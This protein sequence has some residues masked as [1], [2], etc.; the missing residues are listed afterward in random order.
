[1]TKRPLALEKEEGIKRSWAGPK[2]LQMLTMVTGG[3]RKMKKKSPEELRSMK[4]GE[5]TIFRK[6]QQ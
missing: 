2:N 3:F 1:M 5:K 4:A 6:A